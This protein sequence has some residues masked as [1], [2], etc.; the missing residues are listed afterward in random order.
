M[1]PEEGKTVIEKG[2]NDDE[3]SRL[4]KMGDKI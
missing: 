2:G 3:K 1:T 4:R